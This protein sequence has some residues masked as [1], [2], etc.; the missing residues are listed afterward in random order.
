MTFEADLKER[1]ARA[2]ARLV[3]ETGSDRNEHA[4]LT[5]RVF[6]SVPIGNR[7]EQKKK[8]VRRKKMVKPG[9]RLQ[10]DYLGGGLYAQKLA[11]DYGTTFEQVRLSKHHPKSV[12]VIERGTVFLFEER[13]WSAFDIADLFDREVYN[14]QRI[15]WEMET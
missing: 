10:T 11:E 7:M 1:Y 8:P 4:D 14:I 15:L 3:G 12:A 13:H 9:V 2:H 6:H 5:H